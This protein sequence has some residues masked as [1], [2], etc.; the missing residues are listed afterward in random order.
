LGFSYEQAGK[1]PTAAGAY[2]SALRAQP[3]F[4]FAHLFIGNLMKGLR[5]PQSAEYHYRKAVELDPNL[6]DRVD[7]AAGSRD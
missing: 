1:Y 6:R 7:Q 5:Q 2:Y 4:A 3:D